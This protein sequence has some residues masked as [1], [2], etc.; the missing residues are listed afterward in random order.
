MELINIV[1]ETIER[2]MIGNAPYISNKLIYGGD[3]FHIGYSKNYKE[4]YVW[5]NGGNISLYSKKDVVSIDCMPQIITDVIIDWLNG[6]VHCSDCDTRIKKSDIA[7]GYFA[8]VYCQKCWNGKW[9][10]IEAQENYD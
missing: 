1:K 10:E 6:Y 3:E 7:G 5:A 2:L 8:G 4:I 9:K